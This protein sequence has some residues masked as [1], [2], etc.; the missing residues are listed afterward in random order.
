[1]R[2]RKAK[3]RLSRSTSWRRATLKSLARNLL[4]HQSIKTTLHRAK[5]V[6][7][8]VEELISLAKANTLA[9]K[10]EAFRL[11][12]GHP[13][14]TQIF[15][16][17]GPRFA[18]IRG[19]YTRIIQLGKR[20]GDDAQLVLLELTQIVKKEPKKYKKEKETKPEVI[21]KTEGPKEKPVEEKREGRGPTAAVKEKPP[22]TKKPTK[23]FL[24]GLRGIFKKERDSL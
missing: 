12:G 11:L 14:V 21:S 23:K 19:G 1:M 8:M 4:I 18:Q 3:Y 6:R 10:R 13:L 2:H 22:I 16:E 9:A 20:R 7:P 17:L 24:G 5:A 15:K